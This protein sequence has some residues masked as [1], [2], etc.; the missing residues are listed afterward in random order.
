MLHN[1]FKGIWIDRL[2]HGI[3]I[4]VNLL[5][6]NSCM[7]LRLEVSHGTHVI[8]NNIF[9]SDFNFWKLAVGRHTVTN[10]RQSEM[11]CN[12]LRSF[13]SF[14][15]FGWFHACNW[16]S[17]KK[18]A[19]PVRLIQFSEEIPS[20]IPIAAIFPEKNLAVP[21]RQAF[22][23]E[24]NRAVPLR[25]AFSRGK[26]LVAPLREAFSRG[27]NLAVPLREAFSREKTLVA[28]LRQPVS[29]RRDWRYQV[30]ESILTD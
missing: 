1:T 13:K 15:I 9:L 10:A 14:H 24:K 27:T 4:T 11:L 7:D 17:Q 12:L 8:G 26:N 5:Y 23:R 19:R 29:E 2:V 6:N 18:A 16:I 30:S 25:Q 3:R 20:Y 28:P 22:S 21:L